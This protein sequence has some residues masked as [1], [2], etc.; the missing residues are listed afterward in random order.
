MKKLN[1]LPKFLIFGLLIYLT[2]N[3][4][5]AQY[6]TLQG[7][8]FKI[9]ANNYNPMI[10]NYSIEAIKFYNT[11]T[12]YISAMHSFGQNNDFECNNS[13]SCYNHQLLSDF[14]RMSGMGFN[15]MRIGFGPKY[16]NG[17]GLYFYFAKVNDSGVFSGYDS[18]PLNPTDTAD[19]V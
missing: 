8:Q 1:C 13:I 4:V 18:L 19:L 16:L 3:T 17:I 7:K 15:G 2:V 11:N 6:V 12:Y 9:G 5:K 14:N 10:M